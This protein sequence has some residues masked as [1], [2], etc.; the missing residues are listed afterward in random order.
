MEGSNIMRFCNIRSLRRRSPLSLIPLAL[1]AALLFCGCGGSGSGPIQGDGTSG[2]RGVVT[3][4]FG[5][6]DNVPVPVANAYV[7]IHNIPVPV[8]SGVGIPSVPGP[9]LIQVQTDA[10][11]RY[12]IAIRPGDFIV[13][14]N[15]NGEANSILGRK[16]VTVP[17]HQFV[18][19]DV[20]FT[21]RPG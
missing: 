21:T 4:P 18:T 9:T 16:T 6:S 11:G 14:S 17:A 8:Q 1:V 2:V 7:S 13:I 20:P 3:S 12:S 5:T 10:Q 19:V 15:Q